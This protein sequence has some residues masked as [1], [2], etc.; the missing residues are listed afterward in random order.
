VV[1]VGGGRLALER[2]AANAFD[3]V[4]CDLLMPEMSGVDLWVE[5]GRRNPALAARTIL[6]TG[7]G[8]EEEVRGAMGGFAGPI[9]EK[10]F[11]AADLR[12]AV[13]EVLSRT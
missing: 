13:A 12:A 4:V 6:V 5:L 2:A 11:T 1:A 9:V 7:A 8:Q 3:V 10:P